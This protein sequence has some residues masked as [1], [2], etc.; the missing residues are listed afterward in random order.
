[1]D[2]QQ[3]LAREV[4]ITGPAL[5]SAVTTT[6]SISSAP[7]GSGIV[8]ERTDLPGKPRLKA[9][10]ESVLDTRRCLVIGTAQWRIATVEHLL[11]AFHG[12]GVDNAVVSIDNEELPLGDGSSFYFAQKIQ[13]AGLVT[14]ERPREYLRIKEPLWVEGLVGGNPNLPKAMLIALP[15]EDLEI[16]YTFTSDH[17]VT[18][19]QYFHYNLTKSRE[20]FLPEIAPARTIAFREEINYLQS[21]G[22]ALGGDLNCAVVVGKD[23]YEN[24]L[25][26]PNEIVRHKILDILGDLYLLGPLKG[27][28]FALRSG[29][30]LDIELAKKIK[31][32]IITTI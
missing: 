22:L 14:Q 15:G 2:L 20:L 7:P 21:Q 13:E 12:L 25:R 30:A 8:F 24:E 9:E 10:L 11:A 3:T 18:G 28:I 17:Q 23:Q 16:N 31:E 5:H 1:M 19:T 26:F 29:H 4:T 6:I 32:R 27:Q